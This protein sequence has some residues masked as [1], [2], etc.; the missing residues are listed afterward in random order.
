MFGRRRWLWS[1]SF[2]SR[3]Q[4]LACYPVVIGVEI[5]WV[6]RIL[7]EDGLGFLLISK[8]R[9]IE[10]GLRERWGSEHAD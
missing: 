2:G 7:V 10:I 5:V 3:G 8:V 6:A 9:A 1:C 4:A